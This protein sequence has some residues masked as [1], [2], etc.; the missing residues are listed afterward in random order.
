MRWVPQSLAVRATLLFA[1]IA[2]AATGMLGAYFFYS[3]RMALTEHMDTQLMGRVE[4]FRRLVGNA[5]TI[6][7]LHDRPVL[8]ES[9]LGAES[10]VLILRQPGQAAFIDVNPNHLPVPPGLQ[11]VPPDR[12]IGMQDV[13]VAARPGRA[14]E[15]PPMHWVAGL[16]RPSRDGATVEVIAGHP[17]DNEADMIEA[18]GNRVLSSALVAV[19][20]STLLGWLVLRHGLA[21]LRRVR[22]QAALIT[23]INLALRLP[24]GD[25]PSEL[26]DMVVAFNAMLDRIAEGYARLSQF[27]ADLAH[28]VRTPI[29]AL[30]GQ[31]QVALNLPREPAEYQ[32]L[33]ESN[34]EELNRLNHIAQNILFL[35]QADHETL[36]IE[37]KPLPMHEELSRIADYFEGPADERGLRFDVQASGTARV[38]AALLRRAVNNLVQN[39]VAYGDPGTT[40]RLVGT[41]QDGD[42]VI[43]VENDGAAVPADQLSRLFDRFYRGDAARS[44][45]DLS[46]GLG[47]A[48]VKAIMALHGGNASVSCPQ[49]GSIRFE[50][51]FPG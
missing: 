38:D 40:V 16:A 50:L 20:A 14:A 36:Q 29:G 10:D 33:L 32:S 24:E 42:A 48:I 4:H 13:L 5:Q 9:M 12:N 41:Q 18:N 3:G 34:L 45:Q 44:R 51:R 27:S 6:A 2:C 21:P 8:F 30:I 11:P 39:A 26:R 22:A 7:D 37:R 17:F 47:L 43:T 28:E 31:T 49:P 35:A 19:V 23:P 1:L 46:T 25:A 15:A